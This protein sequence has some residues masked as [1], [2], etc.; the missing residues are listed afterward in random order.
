MEAIADAG[1]TG[2]VQIAMDVAASGVCTAV[3]EVNSLVVQL[4]S[5][6]PVLMSWCASYDADQ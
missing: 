2:R 4:V 5:A 1:Y 3:A 6:A